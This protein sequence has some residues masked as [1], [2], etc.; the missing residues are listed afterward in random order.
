MASGGGGGTKFPWRI[1]LIGLGYLF[2]AKAI[3]QLQPA[4]IAHSLQ[5]FAQ[6]LQAGQSG[7]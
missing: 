5:T 2:L 3:P 7:G 6:T 4:N 1:L